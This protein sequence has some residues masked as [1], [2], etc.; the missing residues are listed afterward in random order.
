[1]C[2]RA[3][4]HIPGN[5]PTSVNDILDRAQERFDER[6]RERKRKAMDLNAF[7]FETQ[8]VMSDDID[9]RIADGIKCWKQHVSRALLFGYELT[10]IG[11]DDRGLPRYRLSNWK[12]VS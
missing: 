2:A 9:V 10:L 11:H 6:M 5:C 1:M 4:I 3:P 12:R 8:R 7:H